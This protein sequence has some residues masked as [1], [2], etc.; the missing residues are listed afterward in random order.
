MARYDAQ[1][2]LLVSGQRE[3]DRLA[4]RLRS[5]EKQIIDINRL[6]VSPQQRDPITGR[7]GAD[8]DRQN[9]IRLAGVQRIAREE[10]KRARLTSARLRGQNSELERSILLQS[11]LNSAVDLYER[12]LEEL[13]RG[14]GGARLGEDLRGQIRDIKAAYDA[15]T[16]GGTKNL[17]IVRSLATELGRVVE[18]QNEINRLSSFQSKSFYDTQRFE[19]RIAELRRAG[20]AASEFGGVGRQIRGLRSAQARGSEFEA[21]DISR[22]IKESL[23]RIARDLEAVT[24]QAKTENTARIA[25]RSWEKFFAEANINTRRL[26]QNQKD[27]AQKF[28]SFFEDA[29]NQALEIR[30]NA[31]DT[32]RAWQNFFEDAQKE[33]ERMRDERLS[34]FA[35]RRGK[36]DQYGMEAGPLPA[37][38]AGAPRY[39]QEAKQFANQLLDVENEIGKIRQDS[40]SESLRLETERLSLVEKRK[41]KEAQIRDVLLEAVTFGRGSQVKKAASN[42]AVGGRNALVRGGLGLGAL[43]IGGAYAAAQQAVGNIDLGM[44]QGPAT[45]AASAIGGAINSALGGVP[46]IINQMLSALGNV[47]SSLGLASVAALAF[48]PAMKTAAD[49][50]FLAGQKFGESKFG[51]NIKL[52]L[53]RQTNLFES[54]IN[55]ASEM[56]MVLDASRSGLD[57]VGRKI[58]TLPALPAAGQTAFQGE[59]RRG[60]SGAF[61]GGGAREITNPEFLATAA[62]EMVQRTQEAAQT[63]LMFAEGLGQAAREAKTIADYLREANELRAQGESSTQR[64]IR[65]TVERG[66]IV[67]QGQTSADIAR[68]RSAFLMGGQYSL[69]QVPAGGELLP[70][71]RTETRQSGYREM[72]NNVARISQLQQEILETMSKQQGFVATLGQLER[73]TINDK[74]RSL[75]IQQEENA[76]L[77]RSIEIIRKRNRELRQR[78]VSAMTPQERGS[79]G[80]F[81]TATLRADRRRR[82]EQGRAR[83]E[84][85]RRAASEGLIG[86]AFPLLFGQG[87]GAAALGGAGGAAGGFAGGGFGFGLSL[88]GTALGTAFDQAVQGAKDLGAALQKPVENF[89]QLAQQAFFSSKELE[90]TIKKT[91]EYGNTAGASASIQEEAIKKLGVNGVRNLQELAS[92]SDELGRA[93]SELGQNMLA[94]IAGPLAQFTRALNDLFAPK[95][96]AQRVENLR[97]G[98]APQQREALNRELLAIG[99]PGSARYGAQ[100]K[101]SERGRGLNLPE[102]ELAAKQAPEEI[103]AI[104]DKYSPF[105]IQGKIKLDP[106]QEIESQING[107]QKQLEAMDIGKSLVDQVRNAGREQADLDK[108]RA[109]LVRSYEENIG[110][111]REQVE[112]RIAEQRRKNAELELAIKDAAADLELEK[113][114]Q[115]NREFRGIFSDT[116]AGQTTERVL[117]AVE[118]ITQ[119]Q[120]DGA[121]QRANLELQIQNTAIET[122]KY[123]LQIADRVSRLNEETARRIS[124]INENVKRRNEEYDQNRFTLEKRIAEA[125]L[126]ARESE[127]KLQLETAK[128]GVESAQK[129]GDTNLAKGLQTYVDLYQAQLDV[130]QK[131]RQDIQGISAPAKLA[132][133]S[134]GTAG[135][136]SVDTSGIN[137]AVDAGIRLQRVF[138]GIQDQILSVNSAGALANIE[139]SLNKQIRQADLLFFEFE[140]GGGSRSK[141][142]VAEKNLIDAITKKLGE[143][144]NKASDLSNKLRELLQF[145]NGRFEIIEKIRKAQEAQ[146]KTDSLL[147]LLNKQDQLKLQIQE[148]S[149]S[150]EGFTEVQRLNAEAQARGISLADEQGQALLRQASAIDRLNQKI[151]VINAL[152]NAGTELS[153]S[154]R[155]LVEDF[156]ELGDASQAALKFSEGLGKKGMNFILDIAFKPIEESMQKGFITF[157]EKLG[158]DIKP[159]EQQQ[160]EAVLSIKDSVSVIEQEIPKLAASPFAPA[161]STGFSGGGG[162]VSPTVNTGLGNDLANI[163]AEEGGYGDIAGLMPLPIQRMQQQ[164]ARPL[165]KIWQQIQGAMEGV[166]GATKKQIQQTFK[167]DPQRNQ[168]VLQRIQKTQEAILDWNPLEAQW[169]ETENQMRANKRS[170]PSR[171]P[172]SSFV[173]MTQGIHAGMSENLRKAGALATRSGERSF[174][175]FSDFVSPQQAKMLTTGIKEALDSAMDQSFAEL[176]QFTGSNRDPSVMPSFS[177]A[178]TRMGPVVDQ[179]RGL[180]QEALSQEAASGHRYA[181][182]A[183]KKFGMQ[184]PVGEQFFSSPEYRQPGLLQERLDKLMEQPRIQPGIEGQFEGAMLQGGFFDISKLDRSFG[185]IAIASQN[186]SGLVSKMSD[187][188]NTVKIDPAQSQLNP[189]LELISY[190]EA[191]Q[192]VESLNKVGEGVT[193]LTDK[194][195]IAAQSVGA[196]VDTVA[197]SIQDSGKQVD[198]VI[199]AWGASLG[200]VVT[201]LAGAIAG[202]AGI[203]GGITQMKGGGTYGV[204]TGLSSIFG[205]IGSIAGAFGS[206]SSLGGAAKGFSGG[207]FDPMTGLGAAGPNFGFAKGGMFSNSIVSSP[208]LFRFADGG[209]TRNGLMGE[210]GPEAIMPLTRGPDG[211][212]GVDANGLSDAIAEARGALDEAGLN[213]D[214]QD[215]EET[216]SANSDQNTF[217]NSDRKAAAATDSVKELSYV[218]QDSRGAIEDMKRVSRDREAAAAAIA[219]S[220]DTKELYKLLAPMGKETSTIRELLGSSAGSDSASVAGVLGSDGRQGDQSDA[221]LAARNAIAD[222][223]EINAGQVDG[224]ASDA[225][226]SSRELVEKINNTEKAQLAIQSQEDKSA[227]DSARSAVSTDAST[228]QYFNTKVENNAGQVDGSASSVIR[229]SREFVEKINNTEKAQLAAQSQENKSALDSARSAISKDSSTKEYF[230]TKESSALMQ[231]RET[232]D[233]M[234]ALTQTRQMLN[235]VATVNKERSVERAIEA[236]ASGPVKPIDVRYESQVI[237]SV[238]YVTAEQ[239]RKGISEAAERGRSLTL[240]ALKNSVKARRQIGM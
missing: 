13:S 69:A 147:D 35:R 234:M 196:S 9:R 171:Q 24:R 174:Y 136:S 200:K 198:A 48:A 158:F 17:S 3:L 179:F 124:D 215:N 8:P 106:K 59:V 113:I 235:S 100:Q 149:T 52:T 199:P 195:S 129:S 202:V 93:F 210:A 228:K 214:R 178:I 152:K 98:L 88:V 120:N 10:E 162:T 12:K 139:E 163:L 161:P 36:P 185:E 169:K 54:V 217:N 219:A 16:A 108:Q 236:T 56:N 40:L 2:N 20:V 109:D 115:A 91:I 145:E 164:A 224:S 86:G 97:A 79:A 143:Q 166:Y 155:Q 131:G 192:A 27:A 186:L 30:Q 64:F 82:V 127:A 58:Q 89:D 160:L 135:R 14:G 181:Q 62:G 72:L 117:D 99:G 218:L 37:G 57:A 141:D 71:G 110:N 240:S 47:P 220:P 67:Q 153:L 226:T 239:H 209:L 41:Q 81:D 21:K 65:Q 187:T 119:I 206:F 73:R 188:V 61:M 95:V 203:S 103:Q 77:Q 19:R 184:A 76:E 70:G 205:A 207:Y 105:V 168:Q 51:E 50:V 193:Q 49:A 212:L 191:G 5:I 90:N 4:G 104:L 138:Q 85:I 75:Q 7:L 233:S 83:Q 68:E 170:Q 177:N 216:Q 45:Q 32:R 92:E 148:L 22:R 25:A 132:G 223:I 142:L 137:A 39:F 128:K 167:P 175:D 46:E 43:G 66:R 60:R 63:S 144:E 122:E 172:V 157:A 123:K 34:G 114:K 23:D 201:G 118:S 194:A 229:N 159:E 94:V 125:Q 211:R 130:I 165:T 87:I 190:A 1:I 102:I 208:T 133:V 183:M 238:E 53:D 55:K 222:G 111:I 197:Q 29:A 150:Y 33:A 221:I 213:L 31:K 126:S 18:R 140:M 74:G 189:Q 232:T 112:D 80:I 96:Q 42:V 173:Q 107:L 225:I 151:V 44:L 11:R 227:L 182:E 156:I 230:D 78:P 134:A 237:N 6:G 26:E 38:A 84:S 204:L 180:F 146:F 231:A 15:A 116:I 154:V 101:L 176:R 28:R 121:A